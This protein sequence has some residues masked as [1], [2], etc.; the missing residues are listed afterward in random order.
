M[1]LHSLVLQ[2]TLEHLLLDFYLELV[3][4]DIPVT[5]KVVGSVEEAAVRLREERSACDDHNLM[6]A[7]QFLAA[8]VISV[9]ELFSNYFLDK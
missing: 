2:L 9:I 8:V 7:I 5:V 3:S 1:Y 6:L 4:S